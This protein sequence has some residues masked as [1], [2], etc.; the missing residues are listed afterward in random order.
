MI[1]LKILIASRGQ[2]NIVVAPNK[3]A[4]QPPTNYAI[5]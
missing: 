5:P 2:V 4:I 3:N 1:D